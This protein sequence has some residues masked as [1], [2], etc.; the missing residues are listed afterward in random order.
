MG[1]GLWSPKE[2][3]MTEQL[4]QGCIWITALVIESMPPWI[5]NVCSTSTKLPL[6]LLLLLLF[7][8]KGV[9]LEKW[10]R[11]GYGEINQ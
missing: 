1:H 5:I 6:L 10:M 4:I 2:S 3:D 7:I 8:W 9:I 11:T